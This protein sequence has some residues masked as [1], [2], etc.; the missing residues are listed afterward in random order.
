[1]KLTNFNIN[2]MLG[3]LIRVMQFVNPVLPGRVY[4]LA[5]WLFRNNGIHNGVYIVKPGMG[6]K[7]NCPS[8]KK[9]NFLILEKKGKKYR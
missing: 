5:S 1:M 4:E 7:E 2:I 8:G 6:K 3:R 9:D